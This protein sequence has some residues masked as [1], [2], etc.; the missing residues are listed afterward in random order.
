M[1]ETPERDGPT[2]A[3]QRYADRSGYSLTSAAEELAE[4]SRAGLL[5]IDANNPLVVEQLTTSAHQAICEDSLA[6][7]LQYNGPCVKATRAALQAA[8]DD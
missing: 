2:S 1:P 4:V 6:D 7:C 3:A 8:A 5:V